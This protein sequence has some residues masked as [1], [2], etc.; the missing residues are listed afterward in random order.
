MK[1]IKLL[2]VLIVVFSCKKPSLNRNEFIQFM[3]NPE[4]GFIQTVKTNGINFKLQLI[5]SVL[6]SLKAQANNNNEK[7]NEYY[8][9]FL[10]TISVDDFKEDV[11]KYNLESYNQFD[12]RVR[13]CA[14]NLNN[15]LFII[16]DK[17]TLKCPIHHYERSYGLSSDA[18]ILF[19][20]PDLNLK[21]ESDVKV[22]FFDKIFDTGKK[23]FVFKYDKISRIPDLKNN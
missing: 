4:N 7:D 14:S 22:I 13:Y 11:L 3:S 23:I 18:K 5:P 20:F 17:D 21:S 15:D 9:Y 8:D 12:Y 19:G 6:S 1:L 10:M 2:I 16:N